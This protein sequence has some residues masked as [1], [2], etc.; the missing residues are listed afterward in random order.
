MTRRLRL[1]EVGP[2]DG[3]QNEPQMLSLEQKLSYIERLEAAGLRD[4]E[5]GAFV[6]PKWVP[7]MA[8]SDQLATRLR[9]SSNVRYW[10]LIPN[11]RGLERARAVAITHGCLLAS[12]SEAH[13]Q[14]NLNRT[15]AE[16]VRDNADLVAEARRKGLVLRGYVSVAFGCPYEGAVDFD[17]VL[18]LSEAFLANGCL[19]VSLGDTTGMGYPDQVGEGARRAIE[20]CGAERVAFH[21]HD[22]RGTG[23]ANALAAIQ[24]GATTLDSSTGGIGGCPYAPGASGNLAT[25]DLLHLL[26]RMQ[27]E[28]GVDLARI[29]E[30]SR[31]LRD[32]AGL[33]INSKYF[34]YA[35]SGGELSSGS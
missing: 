16:T 34:R 30:T 32:G 12:A 1:F 6:H 20:R 22:T 3:L 18:R 25:E 29:V 10:A 8:D 33:S 35:V 15:I 21:F 26:D 9:R 5:I 13:S 27:I 19:E 28:T 2:R 14:K 24:A 17:T 23:L 7:Q 31:W 11:Q 4:I